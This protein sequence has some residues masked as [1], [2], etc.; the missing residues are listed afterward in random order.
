MGIINFFKKSRNEIKEE[1]SFHKEWYKKIKNLSYW[2]FN[3]YGIPVGKVVSISGNYSNIK[4]NNRLPF[5]EV[6]SKMLV[7][8]IDEYL[9]EY[10]G[11]N[12]SIK[13]EI[14]A[15]TY[16]KNIDSIFRLE[17]KNIYKEDEFN[18]IKDK[19]AYNSQLFLFF[20][21]EK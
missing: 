8:I 13:E 9:F 7:K 6:E 19:F 12:I 11:Q 10:S 5:K 15:S 1:I 21:F 3:N 16:A 18:F 17:E 14:L 2:I 4:L 20:D